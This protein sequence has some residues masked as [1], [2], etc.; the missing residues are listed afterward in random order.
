MAYRHTRYKDRPAIA[1]D[2]GR[3]TALFLPQ[4][5]GKMASLRTAAGFELLAQA[6]GERYRVLT[7]EGDYVQAECSGFD[8]MF[9]TIDPYTPDR[10]EYAGIPY[11]DHGEVCRLPMAAD[12]RGDALELRAASRRFPL[13]FVKRASACPDGAITVEY[14]LYND[15]RES[16]P[17]IWAG[18]CM[19]AGTDD[20]RVSVPFGAT[21]PIRRMFGPEGPCDRLTGFSPEGATYKFYYTQRVPEGRCVCRYPSQGGELRLT[22]DGERVPYLGI[23]LNN[24]GFKN[25]YNIALEPCTAPY[26]RPDAAA[27]AGAASLLPAAGSVSFALHFAWHED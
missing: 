11:P 19:L 15:G 26:D 12:M 4:D 27:K 22:Y 23:W 8:D 25:M 17:Y 24:G 2:S 14:T 18:H 6:P 13:R 16:F 1:V 21:A 5:G 9:P 20:A 3:L 7:P 10:G